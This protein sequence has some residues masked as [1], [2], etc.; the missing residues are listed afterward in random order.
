V[1]PPFHRSDDRLNDGIKTPTAPASKSNRRVELW[2]PARPAPTWAV[3]P[4]DNVQGRGALADA[5]IRRPATTRAGAGRSPPAFGSRRW[6][7]FGGTFDGRGQPSRA[8][9]V[10]S[11]AAPVSNRA[12]AAGPQNAYVREALARRRNRAAPDGRPVR[13]DGAD[14]LVN[15]RRPIPFAAVHPATR[16]RSQSAANSVVSLAP[17]SRAAGN[18]LRGV[19]VPTKAPKGLPTL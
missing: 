12:V 5:E 14:E 18:G 4:P 9:A 10:V 6:S 8:R 3:A 1:N 17:A 11:P 15:T 2:S 19:K 16:A 7:H 13:T